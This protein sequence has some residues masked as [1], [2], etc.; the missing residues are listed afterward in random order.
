MKKIL[1]KLWCEDDGVLSFEWTIIAVAI[2]FGIVGGLAAVR[3]VL[4]DEL[5]DLGEAVVSFDQSFTF[6]GIPLLGIPGSSYTDIPGTVVDCTRQ[7]VGSWG[8][9]PRDDSVGGA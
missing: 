7:P 8:V 5:G 2:V 3:D 1:R 4:I 9:P 6:T